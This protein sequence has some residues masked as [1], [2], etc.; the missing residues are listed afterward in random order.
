MILSKYLKYTLG[1]A[2]VFLVGS[3]VTYWFLAKP[4]QKQLRATDEKEINEIFFTKRPVNHASPLIKNMTLKADDFQVFVEILDNILRSS[5]KS[6]YLLM[7][8]FT[9]VPLADALVD[10][11]RKGVEILLV[12]DRSMENSSSF[13][14]QKLQ[15]GGVTVKIRDGTTMHNKVVLVD[16]PYNEKEQKLIPPATAPNSIDNG[17]TVAIPRNGLTI[18][19]SMNWTREGLLNNEE[20]FL[21][22]SN[23]DICEKAAGSFF[24]IWNSEQTRSAPNYAP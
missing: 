10:Q 18:T 9:S 5:Q 1:A 16:V 19:G 7:Y 17:A 12:V 22:C 20:N 15:H 24:Q 11:K 6:I 2:V 4:L 13:I 21:V 23:E 8:I 14:I 3:E